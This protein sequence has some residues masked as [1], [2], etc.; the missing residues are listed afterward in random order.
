MFRD[1]KLKSITDQLLVKRTNRLLVKR[2]NQLTNWHGKVLETLACPEIAIARLETWMCCCFF[3]A[4]DVL[5][6][7][8]AI[9][10]AIVAVH[11]HISTKSE[12][13]TLISCHV[14]MFVSIDMFILRPPAGKGFSVYLFSCSPLIDCPQNLLAHSPLKHRECEASNLSHK[15]WCG[16]WRTIGQMCPVKIKLY[17]DVVCERNTYHIWPFCCQLTFHVGTLSCKA[18]N[19][20]QAHKAR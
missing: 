14:V 11:C 4:T 8:S 12:T 10:G 1:N 17:W 16:L 19:V 9:Y 5:Y 15:I 18:P 6:M 7:Y 3:S 13:H 2:T 20:K